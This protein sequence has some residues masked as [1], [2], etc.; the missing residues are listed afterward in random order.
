MKY[1]YLV[2]VPVCINL[3]LLLMPLYLSK[4]KGFAS[5]FAI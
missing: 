2:K 1:P 5:T 4:Q 3:Q